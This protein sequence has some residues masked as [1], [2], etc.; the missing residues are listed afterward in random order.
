MMNNGGGIDVGDRHCGLRYTPEMR[1]PRRR[2]APLTIFAAFCCAALVG[3]T[4]P[5]SADVGN[6]TA[7]TAVASPRPAASAPEPVATPTPPSVSSAPTPDEPAVAPSASAEGEYLGRFPVAPALDGGASEGATGVVSLDHQGT[8][9]SYTV[10]EG[11]YYGA[12]IDRFGLEEYYFIHLNSVRRDSPFYFYAGDVLNLDARTITSVGSQNGI[13][14][15]NE[16]VTPHPP[17]R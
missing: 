5:G 15:N 9:V 7:P 1:R 16:I 2:S 8:A 13:A 14:K 6:A 11:D 3:C 12:I 17:Q 10:A 4:A